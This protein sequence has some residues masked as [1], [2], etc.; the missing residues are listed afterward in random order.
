MWSLQSRIFPFRAEH[1][2]P[3]SQT[4]E[5]TCA[6]YQHTCSRSHEYCHCVALKAESQNKVGDKLSTLSR[7]C[8]YS[9]SLQ[10]QG[11]WSS[12]TMNTV[13]LKD[14]QRHLNDQK[15]LQCHCLSLTCVHLFFF[16]F[17]QSSTF[18]LAIGQCFENAGHVVYYQTVVPALKH[19]FQ[20]GFGPEVWLYTFQN[21]MLIRGPNKNFLPFFNTTDIGQISPF[22]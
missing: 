5:V 1:H 14:K 18:L 3:N 20:I 7:N 11:K 19:C 8:W 10:L 6:L 2:S 4:P 22:H 12:Q 9:A 13:N 21:L 15:N 16:S 17:V